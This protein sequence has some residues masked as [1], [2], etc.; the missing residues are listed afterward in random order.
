MFAKGSKFI[1]DD[2]D[3]I[4]ATDMDEFFNKKVTFQGVLANFSR[5]K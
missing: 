1:K 2:I 3:I 4:W 5:E